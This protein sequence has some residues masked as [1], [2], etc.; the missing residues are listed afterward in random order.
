M[1]FHRASTLSQ[2]FDSKPPPIIATWLHPKNSRVFIR[3]SELL[4]R[5]GTTL[6]KEGLVFTFSTAI[7]RAEP[8]RRALKGNEMFQGA[9]KPMISLLDPLVSLLVTV[10]AVSVKC[11]TNMSLMSGEYTTLIITSILLEQR[12]KM[13]CSHKPHTHLRTSLTFVSGTLAAEI[14]ISVAQVVLTLTSSYY[15]METKL[16]VKELRMAKQTTA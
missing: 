8:S 16:S 7:C 14:I 6:M 5:G 13:L 12:R 10:A 1:V 15:S 11:S 2:V 4:L 9:W 3:T